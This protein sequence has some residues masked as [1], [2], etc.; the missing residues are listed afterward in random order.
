MP[1]RSGRGSDQITG[2]LREAWNRSLIKWW[3][4]YNDDYLDG[5]LK[6]PLISVSEGETVLGQWQA[7]RRRLSISANHIERD[8]WLEVMETLRHEMA[9]QYVTEVLRE[10]DQRPH[11]HAFQQ[12]CHRLRCS[13][14]ARSQTA[15][16][17]GS[18][19][20]DDGS[21]PRILRLIKKTLSLAASPNENEAQAAVNKARDLLLRYNVELVE[22]DRERQFEARRLGPTKGRRASYELWLALLLQDFFFVEVLWVFD[23]D[24]GRDKSGTVLQIHGTSTNLDMA[25][26]TYS[27]LVPT[28]TETL[29]ELCHR[30]PFAGQPA[31]PALLRRCAGR[32][33]SQAAT[34]RAKGRGGDGCTRRGGSERGG[35]Q[36]KG[37]G[38]ERG[39]R[40]CA[41]TFPTSI[42][43][44]E[45]AAGAVWPPT[46]STITALLRDAG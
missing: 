43:M 30:P 26:Y 13:P 36:W 25:E 18:P 29:A 23:Y 14:A 12:A 1:R 3:R 21:D 17:A 24:A 42:R 39:T 8:P 45:P 4:Y 22:L 7:E 35:W 41:S 38:L 44:C 5:I 40:S 37:A 16:A 20:S 34:S 31:A 2:E 33:L 9:H 32:L 15:A 46:R 6:Q 28:A 11:G 19:A 27:Y 10:T